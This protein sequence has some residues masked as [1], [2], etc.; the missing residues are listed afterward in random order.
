MQEFQEGGAELVPSGFRPAVAFLLQIITPV[1]CQRL[2][3]TAPAPVR[4]QQLLQLIRIAAQVLMIH[5][6][7]LI[8][9]RYHLA[10]AA[11]LQ[12]M[13]QLVERGMK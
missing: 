9:K 8:G 4:S 5:H 7:A 13:A 11:L 1:Q 10:I 6:V 3:S 12:G 2:G